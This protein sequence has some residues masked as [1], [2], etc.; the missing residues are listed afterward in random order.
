MI[1]LDMLLW[2]DDKCAK[3]PCRRSGGINLSSYFWAGVTSS[4]LGKTILT[5]KIG[6]RLYNTMHSGSPEYK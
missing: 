5:I 3:S 2:A 4:S 6:N 1:L